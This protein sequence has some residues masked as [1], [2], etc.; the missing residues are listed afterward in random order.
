MIDVN[1]NTPFGKCKKAQELLKAID[2]IFACRPTIK[3]TP[4]TAKQYEILKNSI[5]PKIAE[6]WPVLYRKGRIIYKMIK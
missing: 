5:D 2:A 4:V 6:M 1:K 3:E